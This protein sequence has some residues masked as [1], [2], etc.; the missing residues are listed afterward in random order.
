MSALSRGAP[1][2]ALAA[3]LAALAPLRAAGEGTDAIFA[4]AFEAGDTSA[5][6]DLTDL[7]DTFEDGALSGWSVLN[8]DDASVAEE[9]GALAVEPGPSTLWFDGSSSIL[10]W[11]QVTGNFRVSARVRARRAS[12]PDQV[13]D[14]LIHLGGLMARDGGAPAEN[15]V[16]A[17]VGRD[18]NDLSVEA[19][20]TA[21]GSSTYEGPAWAGAEA[22][23]RL[24]RLGSEFRLYARPLAGGAW[25]QPFPTL[26]TV[27]RPDL[28]ATLQV[29]A[30][31]YAFQPDADLRVTWESIDFYRPQTLADCAD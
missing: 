15:Y 26:S 29:G 10:V 14:E 9:G 7:S 20:T 25:Q 6:G 4:D 17:V 3:L 28:P 13:P 23:L 11:K 31:A 18:E 16:F 30:N 27:D 1:R 12:Q 8:P 21:D 2:A 19:K 24:C 5:W 22:E